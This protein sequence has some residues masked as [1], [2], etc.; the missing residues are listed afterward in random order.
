MADI[1]YD[2]WSAFIL[3]EARARGWAG[4]AMLDLGCGTGNASVPMVEQ[5]FRVTGVDASADMLAVARRKLPT[6]RF[7]HGDFESFDAGGSFTLA[8]SVFDSLNNLLEP[9]AFRRTAER[10]HAHLEPG[11]IFAFDVNT[12]RGLTFLWESGRAEGWAGEVYYNWRHSFDPE[13]G[14]ARVDAF[15]LQGKTA[16]TE[17]H[18]ERPYD[19]PELRS[20][21]A[22]A[23]FEDIDV[24]AYPEGEPAPSDA[25]RVWVFARKP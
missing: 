4:G 14:L 2:E 12:T 9:A 1:E 7:V 24:L 13:S 6:A 21:L 23:G 10:V 18:F 25:H 3:T 11:G 15:C 5:G 19:P 8:Y 16:F 20:L 22:E 17:V